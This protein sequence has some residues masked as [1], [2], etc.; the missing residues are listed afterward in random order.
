[1][2]L[3]MLRRLKAWA[4]QQLLQLVAQRELVELQRRRVAMSQAQRW[5]AEFPDVCDVLDMVDAIGSDRTGMGVLYETRETLRRRRDERRVAD[6]SLG[7]DATLA[8]EALAEQRRQLHARTHQQQ[9]RDSR[10][11]S[12]YDSGLGAC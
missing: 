6:S 11:R 9:G 12:D 5:F 1:M 7:H 4:R 10:R 2:G 8:R 3:A